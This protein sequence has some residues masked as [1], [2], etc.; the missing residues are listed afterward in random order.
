MVVSEGELF[1]AFTFPTPQGEKPTAGYTRRPQRRFDCV[2]Q[3]CEFGSTRRR[4]ISIESHCRLCYFCAE[5]GQRLLLPSCS[6]G[7]HSFAATP[8]ADQSYKV[9]HFARSLAVIN[10]ATI[11][12]SSLYRTVP[13]IYRTTPN[14]HLRRQM[15]L[16]H[17]G[18]RTRQLSS[19]E[20]R[21][22][23]T[24]HTICALSVCNLHAVRARPACVRRTRERFR[25]CGRRTPIARTLILCCG[26]SGCIISISSR[27]GIL[28]LR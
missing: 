5:C 21:P 26:I 16:R 27:A 2:K 14:G 9:G 12:S 24:R 18:S 25:V 28:R 19:S 10:T 4:I 23:R 7:C 11:L 13:V 6:H 20:T 15:R 8:D 17:V 22:F 1:R 3:E